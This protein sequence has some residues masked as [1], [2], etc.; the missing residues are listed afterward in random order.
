MLKTDEGKG[1]VSASSSEIKVK[2]WQ[3]EF[4]DHATGSGT[5]LPNACEAFWGPK[6]D[7]IIQRF[8]LG[9]ALNQCQKIYHFSPAFEHLRPYTPDNYQWKELHVF[10]EQNLHLN[11]SL[12]HIRKLR[13]KKRESTLYSGYALHNSLSSRS[14]LG[15]SH[16]V[17]PSESLFLRTRD[18]TSNRQPFSASITYRGVYVHVVGVL[19]KTASALVKSFKGQSPVMLYTRGTAA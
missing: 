9:N 6:E 8:T 16:H 1:P 12:F 15:L 2:I 14:C 17:K 10:P 13:Q 3:W 19:W 7:D 5:I 18:S 11:S 4:A